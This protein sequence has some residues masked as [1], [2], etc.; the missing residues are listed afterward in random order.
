[1]RDEKERGRGRNVKLSRVVGV[2]F[3]VG[4][5]TFTVWKRVVRRRMEDFGVKEQEVWVLWEVR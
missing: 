2:P 3:R 4:G 1:M 5:A